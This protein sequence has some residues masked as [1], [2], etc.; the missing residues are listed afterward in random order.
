MEF[1]IRYILLFPHWVCDWDISVVCTYV[2]MY[3]KSTKVLC[4]PL[5]MTCS[6]F[7]L[8]TCSGDGTVKLWNFR[9]GSCVC[10][11]QDHQQPG[12]HS[13]NTPFAH[14]P[15]SPPFHITCDMQCGSVAGTP[16]GTT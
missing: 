10:T 14:P 16:V 4:V 11:F 7:V 13:V 5:T 8:A 15:T 2:R 3:S 9:E 12:V 6:G 1:G